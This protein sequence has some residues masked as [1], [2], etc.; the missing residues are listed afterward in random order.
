MG[1]AA[2]DELR[3]TDSLM[4]SCWYLLVMMLLYHEDVHPHAFYLF[5]LHSSLS[6]ASVPSHRRSLVLEDEVILALTR[7]CPHHRLRFAPHRDWG[8]GSSILEVERLRSHADWTDHAAS[9]PF[10]GLVQWAH[11]TCSRLFL[12]LHLHSLGYV[13]DG[14][15]ISLSATSQAQGSLVHQLLERTDFLFLNVAAHNSVAGCTEVVLRLP[16]AICYPVRFH[17]AAVVQ[18]FL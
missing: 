2:V 12:P 9:A 11:W 8:A 18:D 15:M 6:V 14:P 13:Q 17:M 5:D 16:Q 10:L 4:T 3:V 1:F 7:I